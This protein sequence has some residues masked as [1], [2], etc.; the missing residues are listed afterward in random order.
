MNPSAKRSSSAK[1]QIPR[2]PHPAGRVQA[3][4]LDPSVVSKDR[5]RGR[6]LAGGRRTGREGQKT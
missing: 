6:R 1:S 4:H 5:R 2:Q 3:A